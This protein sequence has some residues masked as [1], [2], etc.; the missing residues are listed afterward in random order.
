MINPCANG[1]PGGSEFGFRFSGTGVVLRF[2]QRG[3][4][5]VDGDRVVIAW[6]LNAWR[7]QAGQVRGAAVEALLSYRPGDV[8]SPG[9]DRAVALKG[10]RGASD[11]PRQTVLL[12][13]NPR[14]AKIS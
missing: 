5:R 3:K 12:G 11:R 1:W 9:K 6:V 4:H 7:N 14:A 10:R 13:H 8:P 2:G